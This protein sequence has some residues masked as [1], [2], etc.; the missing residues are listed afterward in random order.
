LSG[1]D[2]ID[3]HT[4]PSS[5]VCLRMLA[6]SCCELRNLSSLSSLCR[7][8]SLRELDFRRNENIELETIPKNF[9]QIL[10]LNAMD[11]NLSN[12]SSLNRLYFLEELDLSGNEHL[13]LDTI[14]NC[15]TRLR[16]LGLR[17]CNLNSLASLERFTGLEELNIK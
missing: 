7:V 8:K 10:K 1:N 14:P 15:L 5:L 16:K 17:R 3:L 2:I 12:V 9:T 13:W 4:I 11:C 6:L